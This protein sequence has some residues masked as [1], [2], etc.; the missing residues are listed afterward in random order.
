MAN[1]RAR[2]KLERQ[3]RIQESALYLFGKL[4]FEAT[5]MEQIAEAAGL[6]VGTLYNYYQS[7]GDLLISLNF[8]RVT[9]LYKVEIETAPAACLAGP[10]PD[11][12]PYLD[13]YIKV[14][15]H[16]PKTIWREY[17][18][19]AITRTPQILQKF[20]AYDEYLISA[21]AQ[22]LAQWQTKGQINPAIEPTAAARVI[23][24]QLFYLMIRFAASDEM[25]LAG[26]RARGSERLTCLLAMMANP[27]P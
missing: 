6:G 23:R 19:A 10:H 21:I 4:G 26:L 5:T 11:L 3:Q 24:E 1:L 15:T 18:A 2:S 7:K 25:D 8:E 9:S 12:S 14:F 17:L 13:V 16:Y 20:D 27:A 22:V